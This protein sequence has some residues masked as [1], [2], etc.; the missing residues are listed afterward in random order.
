M[1][2]KTFYNVIILKG[3]VVVALQKNAPQAKANIDGHQVVETKDG[4]TLVVFSGDLDKALAS[5]VIATGARSMGKEVT[6]FFTFWGLNIIK[7]PNAPRK[8]KKG[9][10][11]VFSMM[12]PKS[13]SKLPI[14]KMN[15][16]GMGSRMIQYVMKNKK[17]DAVTEMIEKAD[18][19]GIK[20]IA[21]TM[22]MDVMSIDTDEL[23]PHVNLGG[24]GTYLGDAENGNLN[25]FI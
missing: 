9:L 22:S 14:S 10:D 15:M 12:M 21:C 17:V 8:N 4:A 20:M 1:Y 18:K 13:A 25:L 11:K 23:L 7:D 16:F 2:Y 19:L 6:M 3:K 5:F 24:V